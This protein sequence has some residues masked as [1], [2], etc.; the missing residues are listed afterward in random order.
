MS[1]TMMSGISWSVFVRRLWGRGPLVIR[2]F[3]AFE[4]MKTLS[5]GMEFFWFGHRVNG[6]LTAPFFLLV[7]Y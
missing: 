1:V 7:V 4:H 5:F 2:N 6:V 3:S